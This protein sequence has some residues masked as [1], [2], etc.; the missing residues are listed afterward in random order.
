MLDAA[1]R[2]SRGG[3][4]PGAIEMV[5]QRW[6]EEASGSAL[7]DALQDILI[8]DLPDL[9]LVFLHRTGVLACVLPEVTAMIDFRDEYARHKDLWTHTVKVVAQVEASAVLRWAALLHDIGKVRTRTID[10]RGRV[11]FFGH[12]VAGARMFKQVA[13]R[14][15]FPAPQAERIRFL[16]RNHL[17]AGQYEPGWTDSAVRRFGREM[18]DA[19]DELIKLSRADITTKYERKKSRHMALLGELRTRVEAIREKDAIPPALPKGLGNALMER[20][21]LEPGRRLGRLMEGLRDVVESGGLPRAADPE[22]YLRY[23]EENPD[24]LSG[25]K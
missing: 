16:I 7:R 19:L 25:P 22:V 21:S 12:E 17:R 13:R 23:L 10:E 15:C 5:E 4:F 20:Y 11:H 14:L 24:V 9:A 18:G 6:V 1:A 8:G 2:G 3:V